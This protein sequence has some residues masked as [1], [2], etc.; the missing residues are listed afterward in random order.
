MDDFIFLTDEGFTF[1]PDSDATTP[2]IENMQVIGFSSGR[3]AD[4]A[5]DN[6]LN[7]YAYLK[8]TSFKTIFCYKLDKHYEENRKEYEIRAQ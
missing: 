3:T 2:D 1:Q 7:T 6:L 8:D 5:F 4:E